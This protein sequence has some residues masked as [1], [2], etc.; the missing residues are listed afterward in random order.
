MMTIYPAIDLKD[1]QCVR[2]VQGKVENKTV[3]SSSPAEVARRFQKQGARWLHIVDLDGAFTGKP[4]N[5]QAIEAIADAVSIPF[6]VGGGLRSISDIERLLQA[7]AN[8]V[9]IGTRAVDGPDFVKELLDEFGDQ[10]IVLGLDVRD[11]QVAV[12][13][14]IETVGL[15]AIELG[16]QMRDLGIRTAVYTDVSRDGLLSGPNMEATREVAIKTG[17][18]VIA[19]GGVSS[20]EHIKALSDMEPDGVVGAIIGKA[21]YDGKITLPEALKASGKQLGR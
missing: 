21:L 9:I 7:G 4:A 17:L 14:W 1:G 3:Y 18:S 10:Q 16:L 12:Q 6:Q 13:G 5:L 2:L 19:S 8:R 15:T 11:G 20:V